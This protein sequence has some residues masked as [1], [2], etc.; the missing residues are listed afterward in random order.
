MGNRRVAPLDNTYRRHSS[1]HNCL[2][3]MPALKKNILNIWQQEKS[4]S[5]ATH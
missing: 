4:S 1:R 2:A 5:E 3:Q